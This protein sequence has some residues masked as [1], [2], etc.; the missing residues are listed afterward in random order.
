METSKTGNPLWKHRP[1]QLLG[2]AAIIV[3]IVIV[4]IVFIH[5]QYLTGQLEKAVARGDIKQAK[6][7]IEKGADPAKISSFGNTSEMAKLLI[8][9]GRN[10][11][12]RIDTNNASPLDFFIQHDD[13]K[14]VKWLLDNGANVN[15]RDS[16]GS[17]ALHTATRDLRLIRI[18]IEHGAEI[19]IQDNNGNTPLHR[20]IMDLKKD[21]GRGER[22]LKSIDRLLNN[23]ADVNIKNK[24]GNTPLM[25]ALIYCD[26]LYNSYHRENQLKII[27]RILGEDNIDLMTT[28]K[29]GKTALHLAPRRYG[30][31]KLIKEKGGAENLDQ[32]T[33][34]ILDRNLDMTSQGANYKMLRYLES[35]GSS[36]EKS[37][38][39]I[40][41]V[42]FILKTA[43]ID[44]NWHSDSRRGLTSTHLLN[45]IQI[46]SLAIVKKLIDMGADVNKGD[47]HPQ[48][49]PLYFAVY[50][51]YKNRINDLKIIELLLKNSANV[52]YRNRDDIS[53]LHLAVTKADQNRTDDLK[54]IE[55]LLKN[56]ADVNYRNKDDISAYGYAVEHGLT[57]TAKVRIAAEADTND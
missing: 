46:D 21:S 8:E 13:I 56:G 19:N 15:A 14:M 3:I 45:A 53:I 26:K 9:N 41:D 51:M 12:T 6:S 35:K 23:G 44:P 16:T 17:A 52:N 24:E 54:I 11:D 33:I 43:N 30:I 57:E 34:K 25:Y 49:S 10:I 27:K 5:P 50:L 55:L 48:L 37:D 38:K 36:K 20:T 4:A 32:N 39:I 42:L 1:I 22:V 31:Y 7:L 47:R 28:N 18:L 40:D 2:L 29:Q